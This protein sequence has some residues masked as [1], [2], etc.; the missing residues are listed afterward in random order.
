[1]YSITQTTKSIETKNMPFKRRYIFIMAKIG[2]IPK[3]KN[4]PGKRGELIKKRK[5]RFS[6]SR[7]FPILFLENASKRGNIEAYLPGC[8]RAFLRGNSVTYLSIYWLKK[9][10]SG[11]I[12]LK[13]IYSTCFLT[14]LSLNFC[15]TPL[16]RLLNPHF[17]GIYKFSTTT[18]IDRGVSV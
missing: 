2:Q 16:F 17:K 15:I 3:D 5:I 13:R 14:I 9:G 11:S 8:K 12:P 6:I 10:Y 7:I 1:M 18:P 4:Q